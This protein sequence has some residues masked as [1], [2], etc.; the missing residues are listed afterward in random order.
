MIYFDHNATTPLDPS[1]LE[2][3]MPFLSGS[4]GNP[5][6]Q[7]AIGQEARRAVERS[8]RK[9]AD[10]VGADP[11]SIIF[12]GS[13]TEA[14]N[15]ALR[16]SL[17]SGAFKGKHLIVGALEHPSV[18]APAEALRREGYEV[19]IAPV[20]SDGEVRAEDIEPLL[21]PD[22]ALISVMHAQNEVGTI[23]QVH[24]ICELIGYRRILVHCDA[25][26]SVGKIPTS[27]PLMG[28][29]LMT[30]VAHKFHGPKGIGAAPT[31]VSATRGSASPTGSLRL[32]PRERSR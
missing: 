4:Y 25:A 22:T 32:R 20:T 10:L 15:L 21:R 16:G 18:L 2:A 14:N 19:S 3:M 13:G 6:S 26:Q 27:F 12:T 5:S 9:I 31:G 23:N 8:R 24:E 11:R 17:T 7:H 29:N 1:V 30:M 28:T